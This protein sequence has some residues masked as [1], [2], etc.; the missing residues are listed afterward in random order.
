MNV[1]LMLTLLVFTV[2]TAEKT[3]S[4]GLG[5]P[6]GNNHDF[7]ILNRD[8]SW[9]LSGLRFQVGSN[10][11][12]N[13][14]HE[15]NGDMRWKYD[16]SSN[17]YS[18][19][20]DKMRLTNNGNLSLYSGSF[21]GARSAFIDWANTRGLFINSGSDNAFFGLKNRNGSG[22]GGNDYNTVIYFGD[23]TSDDLEFFT[24]DN[25][26]V[27]RL[28]GDGK[29]GIGTNNPGSYKLAVEG[30]IGARGV[31][32]KVGS[33]ADFVFEEDYTLKPLTEVAA[34]IEKNKHLPDVPSEAEVLETG[35][36]IAKMD[37][38]LLQ[39]IEELTLY[40]IELEKKNKALE[41]VVNEIAR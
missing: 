2:F 26:E 17:H 9:S 16:Q 19:G 30:K 15:A 4:Q 11:A 10:K 36:D 3:F 34:F 35:I 5:S 14:I 21:A 13:I 29:L 18:Q 38:L 40:V 23:D 7:H 28:T 1:Y 33:W 8:N 41:K 24:Q 22:G 31:D 6:T 27:M 12:W 37:A 20:N 32:V 39:K 25:G